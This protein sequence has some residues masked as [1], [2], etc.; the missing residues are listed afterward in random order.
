[1]YKVIFVHTLP[2]AENFRVKE[3]K[4]TPAKLLKSIYNI[5][6]LSTKNDR[7]LTDMPPAAVLFQ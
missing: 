5:I 3:E 7:K 6:L 4:S 2:R 1:M